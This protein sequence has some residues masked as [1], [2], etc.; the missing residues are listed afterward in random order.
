MK[1]KRQVIIGWAQVIRETPGGTDPMTI[2]QFVTALLK[3]LDERPDFS[4]KER[5]DIVVQVI[6]KHVDWLINQQEGTD[7]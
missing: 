4:S 5:H 7:E 3:L 1:T 2:P 6:S